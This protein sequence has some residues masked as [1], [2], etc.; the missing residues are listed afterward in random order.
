MA[1]TW[2]IKRVTRRLE[3]GHVVSSDNPTVQTTEVLNG[4][5][6]VS[7]LGRV[8]YGWNGRRL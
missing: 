5:Q 3:G 7:V 1:G 2:L 8:V 6:Q 4:S